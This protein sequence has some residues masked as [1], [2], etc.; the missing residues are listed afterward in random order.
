MNVRL[1]LCVLDAIHQFCV[2]NLK[3][4]LYV[5]HVAKHASQFYFIH[6]T[7]QLFAHVI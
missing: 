2:I 4:Q 6:A 1:Q 3:H 7:L 5:I